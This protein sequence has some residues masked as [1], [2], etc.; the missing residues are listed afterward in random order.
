MDCR[1]P[2]HQLAG[3]IGKGLLLARIDANRLGGRLL[4]HFGYR[5]AKGRVSLAVPPFGAADRLT[6]PGPLQPVD[7]PESGPSTDGSRQHRANGAALSN[8]LIRAQQQ[9]L[10]NRETECLGGLQVD[11]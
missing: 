6:V 7:R 5:C 8:H 1:L 3:I 2:Q 4:A 10:R 11:G 9:R